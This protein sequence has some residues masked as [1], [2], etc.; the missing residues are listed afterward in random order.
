MF[1]V[2]RADTDKSWKEDSWEKAYTVWRMDRCW[3]NAMR[4]QSQMG[5]REMERDEKS[6]RFKFSGCSEI[7]S[8]ERHQEREKGSRWRGL[9]V[10][11]NCASNTI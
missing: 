5:C 9:V 1:F 8:D 6:V 7:K 11:G 2:T 3:R 4:A 10:L